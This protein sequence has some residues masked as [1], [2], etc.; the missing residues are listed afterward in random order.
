MNPSFVPSPASTVVW[1]ALGGAFGAALRFVVGELFR[2]GLAPTSIPWG[3]LLVNTLGSFVLGYFTRWAVYHEAT[4]QVRAFV[5]IGVCGGFT[6]F[7]AFALEHLAL[8]QAGEYLRAATYTLLSLLLTVAA[9][10]L[11]FALAR[12]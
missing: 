10:A 9:V 6:T 2:R 8:L 11:G 12:G 1:V 3:T 7:S 5:A 4:P